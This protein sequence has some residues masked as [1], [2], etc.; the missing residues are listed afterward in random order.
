MP[1]QPPCVFL[2]Y[3]HADKDFATLLKTGLD[4][5]GITAWIDQEGIEVG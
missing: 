2:S 4:E 5:Q 1:Q 3:A